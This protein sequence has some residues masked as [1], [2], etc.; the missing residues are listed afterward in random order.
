MK[1]SIVM[2]LGLSLSIG[3]SGCALREVRS[4]SKFGPEWQHS[5]SNSTDSVRYSAEQGFD[6]KWQNDWT[7]GV[8]YRRRDIDN[9]D[10]N[11][12]NGAWFDFSFPLWKAAKKDASAERVAELERRITQLEARLANAEPEH[13][14]NL[15]KVASNGGSD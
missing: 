3:V 9:G 10:G 15:A 5:G 12:D 1:A 11:N 7:T 4:Q 13:V 2:T 14:A 6:F 8:S